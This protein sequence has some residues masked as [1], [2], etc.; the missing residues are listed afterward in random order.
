MSWGAKESSIGG[1]VR[2]PRK[3]WR[4]L[5]LLE[6]WKGIRG[7]SR[8][9]RESDSEDSRKSGGGFWNFG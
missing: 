1:A 8:K 4:L 7:R 9:E 6:H 5:M 2:R 3:A